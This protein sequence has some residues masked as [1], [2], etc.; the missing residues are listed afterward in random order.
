[1]GKARGL[2]LW[3]LGCPLFDDDGEEIIEESVV[4]SKCARAR[5]SVV[6]RWMGDHYMLGFEPAP[7]SYSVQTLQKSFS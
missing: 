3:P 5:S 4:Q 1:M 2:A 7:E 6:T